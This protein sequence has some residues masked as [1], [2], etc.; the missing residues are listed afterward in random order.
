MCAVPFI[1]Y[2]VSWIPGL[3]DCQDFYNILDDDEAATSSSAATMATTSK[4]T[5]VF[6]NYFTYFNAVKAEEQ[7]GTRNVTFTQLM[8][9]VIREKLQIIPAS[10]R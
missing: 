1:D 10:V 3:V 7:N 2:N 9:T 8:N 5:R 4:R 6:R